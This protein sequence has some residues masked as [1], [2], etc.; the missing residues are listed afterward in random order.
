M[1]FPPRLSLS[2]LYRTATFF[3][4]ILIT[5]SG[6]AYGSPAQRT[7]VLNQYLLARRSRNSLR[8]TGSPGEHPEFDRE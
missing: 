7:R 6:R 1:T 5:E 2:L 4:T 3:A 8:I